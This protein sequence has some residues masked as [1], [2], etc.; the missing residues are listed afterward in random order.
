MKSK[1]WTLFPGNRTLH[2]PRDELVNIL[3]ALDSDS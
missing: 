1:T 3:G 2:W